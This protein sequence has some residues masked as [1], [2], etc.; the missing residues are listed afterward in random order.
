M[1]APSGSWWL[2]AHMPKAQH[3]IASTTKMKNRNKGLETKEDSHPWKWPAMPMGV[4][5]FNAYAQSIVL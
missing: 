5:N 2:T 3:S 4:S 1:Q